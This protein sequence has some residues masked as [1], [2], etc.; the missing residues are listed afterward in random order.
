MK[1]TMYFKTEFFG[2]IAKLEVTI[3]EIKT[4]NYAQYKNVVCV[5]YIQKKHRH[6]RRKILVGYEPFLIICEGWGHPE[7]ADMY[8][9]TTEKDGVTTSMSVYSSFDKRYVSD[10]MRD[11]YPQLTNIIKEVK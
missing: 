4:I 7:P 10:F 11:I 8:G 5:D 2:N 6:I 1:A 3:K 9:K